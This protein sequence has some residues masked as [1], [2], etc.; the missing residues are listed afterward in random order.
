[1]AQLLTMISGKGGSGKTT[2]ALS[3]TKLLIEC[4]LK[5]LVIDCDLATNGA[6]YFFEALYESPV[7]T[8]R[9]IMLDE[10]RPLL[11]IDGRAFFIPTSIHFPVEKIEQH[12]DFLPIINYVKSVQE[13]YDVIIC[14]CQAGYSELMENILDISDI[15]LLVMEPDAISNSAARV[16]YTQV[17][18][19]LEAKKTYQIFNKITKEENEVYKP[20]FFGTLFTLL[21]SV[22]FNWNVRKAFAYSKV[23]ELVTTNADFGKDV[24]EIAKI[25]F[26]KLEKKLVTYEHMVLMFEQ[27]E[28]ETRIR[29]IQEEKRKY[30]N[31]GR[32]YQINR[33]IEPIMNICTIL[34]GGGVLAL[35][36]YY[37]RIWLVDNNEYP[38][39]L[40]FLVMGLVLMLLFSIFYLQY[41]R[42]RRESFYQLETMDRKLDKMRKR[43]RKIDEVIDG[44]N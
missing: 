27:D 13:I 42:R 17:S 41:K 18:S 11:N 25:L 28:L 15:N 33:F 43:L 4:E 22:I 1:M 29:K 38:F 10:E 20:I 3:L 34:V 16:L 8:F 2:L 36:I 12:K 37:D 21:P 23:P 19:Q 26:P 32:I 30:K 7:L 5:V 9:D 40:L 14:D 39:F 44:Y 31:V 6:T 35:S 24:Y